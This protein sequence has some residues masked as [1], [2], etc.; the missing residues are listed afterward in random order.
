M[1]AEHL[2]RQDAVGGDLAAEAVEDRRLAVAALDL[3]HVV[4]GGFLRLGGAVV[5][6]GRT[7]E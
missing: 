2:F 6:S 1:L 4:A 5:K 3:Q 7:P